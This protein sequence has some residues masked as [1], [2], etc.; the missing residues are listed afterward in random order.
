MYADDSASIKMLTTIDDDDG[1]R[2]GIYVQQT[3][4]S[5]TL[6]QTMKIRIYR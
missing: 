5:N 1:F 3:R 6:T 2:R 4:T